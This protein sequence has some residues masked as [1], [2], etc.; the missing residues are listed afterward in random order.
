MT[1]AE[2]TYAN[3]AS[4]LLRQVPEFDGA[5]QEHLEEYG[6]LVPSVLLG[7]LFDFAVEI[8]RLGRTGH[9]QR[10]PQELLMQTV[11]FLEDAGNSADP[12]VVDLVLTGF[13]ENLDPNNPDH[14]AIA[15]LLKP[16]SQQLLQLSR[17]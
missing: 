15:S 9:W 8:Q 6:E 10:D 16:K 12:R 2:I 3:L 11:D 17:T 7:S 1:G 13:L 4:E 14:E 5:Y